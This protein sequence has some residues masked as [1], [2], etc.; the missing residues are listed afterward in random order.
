MQVVRGW[1]QV[2]RGWLWLGA[3][4]CQHLKACAVTRFGFVSRKDW[5]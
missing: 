4:A 2:V 3:I 1:M 5:R